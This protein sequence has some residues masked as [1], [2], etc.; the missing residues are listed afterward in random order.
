MSLIHE[1]DYGTPA[2]KSEAMVTLTIDGVDRTLS[3]KAW[4]TT[5][6][7]I[8][9]PRDGAIVPVA[10]GAGSGFRPADVNPT[11]SDRRWLGCRLLFE[12]ITS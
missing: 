5:R 11:S 3:L 10:V 4:E 8:P 2:S 9:V 1:I 7:R 12:L 6:V